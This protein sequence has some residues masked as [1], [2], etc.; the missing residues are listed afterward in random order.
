MRS[1]RAFLIRL[2]GCLWRARGEQ[3]LNDE[4]ESHLQLHID[5]NLRAGMSP[6]EARRQAVLKLG[7]IEPVKEAMRDRQRL[8]WLESLAQDMRF[9]FR[10]LRKSPGFTT[11]AI[12]TLALCIGANSAVFSVV[13]RLLLTPFPWPESERLVYVWGDSKNRHYIS[14]SIPD[15]LDR[16][17]AIAAFE[18]SALYFPGMNA[19]LASAN[20]APEHV[21][22]MR[23]TPSFFPLVKT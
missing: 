17:N 5:D 23:V 22:G 3:E 4:I 18:E 11:V 10:S 12:L 20:A 8:P 19:N 21:T 6:D 15:Y 2:R 13:H 7:G 9:A 14:C 1:I 16:R